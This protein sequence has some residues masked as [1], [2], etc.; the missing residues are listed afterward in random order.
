MCTRSADFLSTRVHGGWRTERQSGGQAAIRTVTYAKPDGGRVLM[1][2]GN[3]LEFGT[4]TGVLAKFSRRVRARLSC[5]RLLRQVRLLRTCAHMHSVSRLSLR[6]S[7]SMSRRRPG[8]CGSSATVAV[9]CGRAP[10][11]LSGGPTLRGGDGLAGSDRHEY[12]GSLSPI[13]WLDSAP[14]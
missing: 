3:W 4:H 1:A 5:H 7:V 6:V 11:C 13:L 14:G 2:E 8:L 10:R 9:S 12:V